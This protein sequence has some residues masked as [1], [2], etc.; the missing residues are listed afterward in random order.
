[1]TREIAINTYGYI[2]ST[3]AADCVRRLAALGYRR[4][5]LVIHPPHLPLDGFSA[6]ARRELRSAIEGAGARVDALN[7][8]SLDHNL[9]SAHARVRN[10]SV[11]M[12]VDAIDLAADLGAE[13]LITIPGRMNAL[14]PPS[15]ADR[16]KWMT[17]SVA[18]LLP[19]AEARG[20]GLAIE[21]VPFGAFPD[22]ASLG[23]FAR[24]FDSK[25]IGVCYD[26]ANAHFIGESPADGVHRLSD[27]IRVAHLSDTGRDVWR[28][29]RIGVGG[30]P[31]GEFAQALND[32]GFDGPCTL[33]IVEAA[34]EE[35]ILHSHRALAPFGFAPCLAG[36][37]A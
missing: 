29:D 2:W 7:L 6:A 19:R 18:A 23:D 34:A 21:N 11:A 36:P 17:E 27:L 22:A 8:P 31:C 32:V 33:E 16:A 4:F 5:E 12:F 24:G 20:V 28:H 13:W 25:A 37:A 1:M 30:V 15:A 35:A 26:A 14:F 3:P 9:A 10:A